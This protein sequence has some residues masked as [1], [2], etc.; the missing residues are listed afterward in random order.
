VLAARSPPSYAEASGF[1][2]SEQRVAT[3]RLF[4]T[5]VLAIGLLAP[6]LEPAAQPRE[7]VGRI[8]YLSGTSGIGPREEAFRQ[9]LHD[10]G[11]VEGRNIIIEWRW[12]G[13]REDRLT[14]LAAELVRLMIDVVV[15]DGTRATRA[16]RSVTH[17]IPIVMASDSDPVGNGFVMGL[18]RPGGNITGLTTLALDLSR[19]RLE[20][21]KEAMPSIS[22]V[23]V[24]WN[25]DG[26]S[27]AAAFKETEAAGQALG[28]RLQSL[29]VRGSDDFAG[30]FLAAARSQVG[31][32]TVLSDALMFAR[33]ELILEL[34]ARER[35]ATMHTQSL[36]VEAGGLMSYGTHFPD[37]YRRAAV[38]VDKIL[39][40]ANPADLPVEQPA[41]F[42]LV[43]NLKTANAL[44]LTFPQSVLLRADRVIR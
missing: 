11:Y 20:V 28:L 4:V 10:L 26:P 37:L 39:R 7:K 35:L 22:R 1:E 17:S 23:G 15:T 33:R 8:G 34:A 21:I 6:P 2:D 36:W 24:I 3:P 42:E 25:P 29:A 14:A 41:R 43:I 31:A 16:A 38:Y 12:A 13:G 40:G 30:V 5:V 27:S 9:G 19:K 44:G 32:V 18:A